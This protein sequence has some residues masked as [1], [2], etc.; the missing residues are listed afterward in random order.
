MLFNLGLVDAIDDLANQVGD[1]AGITV[2]TYFSNTELNFT[3]IQAVSM[4]RIIQEI[5]SNSLKHAE[6]NRIFIQCIESNDHYIFTIEDDGK[7]MPKEAKVS[8]GIG[9][10]NIQSRVEY[11]SGKLELYSDSNGTSFEIVIPKND[12]V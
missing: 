9:L 11:L 6:A 12:G 3:D 5:I 10:K 7:G 1:T 2:D 4:Y 8:R